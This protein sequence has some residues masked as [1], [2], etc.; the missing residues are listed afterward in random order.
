MSRP[1]RRPAAVHGGLA[2]LVL[3]LV[4]LC[5]AAGRLAEGYLVDGRVIE[6]GLLQLRLAYNTGAAFSI[7]ASLPDGVLL[8][9]SAVITL[10]VAGYT[11]RQA[12]RVGWTTCL[13]LAAILAG[14]VANLVDRADDGAVIDYLHTGWW[15]TFNLPDTLITVGASALVLAT[16][17][18]TSTT[19][20]TDDASSPTADTTGSGSAATAGT[21]A[22]DP[23][24]TSAPDAIPAAAP[25]TSAPSAVHRPRLGDARRT[26]PLPIEDDVS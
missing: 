20:P 11:W 12:P 18:D 24:N 6:L 10:A 22:S 3:G 21:G 9:V 8:V 26:E 14:A 23:T 2:A 4:A 1:G 15:P 25:G 5:V 17:R 16:L 7:G 19:P 13:G